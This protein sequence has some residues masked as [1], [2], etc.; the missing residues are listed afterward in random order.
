M[1]LAFVP[2]PAFERYCWQIHTS[3]HIVEIPWTYL[4]VE[5][6][7]K[8]SYLPY[9]FT[10]RCQTHADSNT[11]IYLLLENDILDIDRI[12]RGL[13]ILTAVT[14][15]G[16]APANGLTRPCRLAATPTEEVG[17]TTS[18]PRLG[19]EVTGLGITHLFFHPRPVKGST[20][21]T[22]KSEQCTRQLLS[23]H[24]GHIAVAVIY[25]AQV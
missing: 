6:V 12:I 18:S 3:T 14:A 5:G 21:S 9:N 20:A 4:F 19:W 17:A 24:F 22:V 2:A 15:S 11:C 7:Y 23:E 13:H 8:S 1:A 16:T 25:V 10:S